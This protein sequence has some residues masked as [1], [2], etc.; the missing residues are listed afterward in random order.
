MS[1]LNVP[2][3]DGVIAD[4]KKELL[5]D[6][7]VPQIKRDAHPKLHGCV[8][9]EL[10]VGDVDERFRYGVFR[11]PGRYRT[12]VR[13]SNAFGIQHDLKAQ[14]RG[15]ALK[16]LDTPGAES[17]FLDAG[18]TEHSTQDFLM[19]T[20]DA[21]FLASPDQYQQFAPAARKGSLAVVRYFL[22]RPSRW[23]GGYGLYKSSSVLT[24][25]PLAVPYFSQTPYQLGPHRVKLQA[26]PTLTPELTRSLPAAA[27]YKFKA[28]MVGFTISVTRLRAIKLLAQLF[29][30]NPTEASVTAACDRI[31]SRDSLRHALMAFLSGHEA[32]FRLQVQCFVNQELT[33][34]EDATQRWKPADSKFIPVATLRIPRQVFWPTAGMPQDVAEAVARMMDLGE[35]MSFTPWH[36]VRA[37]APLGA[38]NLARQRIYRQISQ[39]RRKKNGVEESAVLAEQ[40]RTS[41][42]ALRTIVQGVSVPEA[43]SRFDRPLSGYS[44]GVGLG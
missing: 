36:G 21:F 2:L 30:R 23:R 31:A 11:Q 44:A 12:W 1:E 39:F 41:Y 25:N 15:L 32:E 37:H 35:N 42:D 6:Y 14:P 40:G 38:I 9:A 8:Q 34:I 19:A 20:Y 16:I 10:I 26:T 7:A 22:S 28:L 17:E 4:V 18:D 5:E 29:G 13:F 27:V 33:P 24:R 43:I 3:I